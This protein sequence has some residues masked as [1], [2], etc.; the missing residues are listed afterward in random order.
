MYAILLLLHSLFRWMVLASLLSSIYVALNGYYGQRQFTAA[1]D[2]FRHW[3]A[4]MAHIQF[5]LGMGLYFLS[6]VV[7]AAGTAFSDGWA[8][9]QTFFFRYMHAALMLVVVTVVTIGSAKA[10]R[11]ETDRQKFRT[12]L[13]WFVA[14]L[15]ILFLAVPWPFSPLVA[16]PY[17]RLF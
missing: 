4:T 3:T 2:K 7:K 9:D 16:R 14:A 5:M 8:H 11:M 15:V 10:K 6:P 13:R 1:A 12:M 17:Y